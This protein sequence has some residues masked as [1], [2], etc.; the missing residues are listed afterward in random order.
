MNSIDIGLHNDEESK[1]LT[2][3]EEDKDAFSFDNKVSVISSNESDEVN[4]NNLKLKIP[5]MPEESVEISSDSHTTVRQIVEKLDSATDNDSDHEISSLHERPK[6]VESVETSESEVN[7]GILKRSGTDSSDY[8][9]HS[10][11]ILDK[12]EAEEIE[13][14]DSIQSAEHRLVR[15]HLGTRPPA[16]DWG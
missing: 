5:L 6:S 3:I 2:S 1:P 9:L 15:L 14:K 8:E 12:E 13:V 16:R 4:S 10:S 11:I 7:V